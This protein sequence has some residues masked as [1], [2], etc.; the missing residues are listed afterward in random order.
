LSVLVPSS[1]LNSAEVT[2]LRLNSDAFFLTPSASVTICQ[3]STSMVSSGLAIASSAVGNQ[4][5]IGVPA[6]VV[7]V[8]QVHVTGWNRRHHVPEEV[9]NVSAHG[10]LEGP[11]HRDVRERRRLVQDLARDLA[12]GSN[13]GARPVLASDPANSIGVDEVLPDGTA[14]P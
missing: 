10:V 13:E 11:Q 6:N 1:S 14:S 2:V 7:E 3:S 5:R 8:D 4:D 9:Q 12:V